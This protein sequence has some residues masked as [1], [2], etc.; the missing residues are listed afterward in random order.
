M[1]SKKVTKSKTGSK[2]FNLAKKWFH[3]TKISNQSS[4]FIYL[5]VYYYY[6]YYYLHMK[7]SCSDN[8]IPETVK[9][10]VTKRY[11]LV[12]VVGVLALV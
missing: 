9:L 2:G 1:L 7:F 11:I 8:I 5:F 12:D 3:S 10:N 4:M 6:Y